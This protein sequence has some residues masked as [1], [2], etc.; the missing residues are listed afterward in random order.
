M[1]RYVLLYASRARENRP[2]NW[3]AL[4]FFFAVFIAVD[5]VR[6]L[7]C[8]IV[9]LMLLPFHCNKKSLE[10]C[11]KTSSHFAWC[12]SQPGVHHSCAALYFWCAATGISECLCVTLDGVP[13]PGRYSFA[14]TVVL[15]AVMWLASVLMLVLTADSLTM[16]HHNATKADTATPTT[17]VVVANPTSTATVSTPAAKIARAPAH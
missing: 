5:N 16:M 6:G 4:L 9:V 10:D 2:C 11:R 7:C 13:H 14:M 12:T 17:V 15:F 3:Q 1:E 8:V